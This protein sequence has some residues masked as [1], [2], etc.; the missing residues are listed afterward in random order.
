MTYVHR[1]ARDCLKS[2]SE[3]NKRT[4]DTQTAGPKYDV[5]DAVWLHSP[6][7]RKGI[8]PK[9]QSNW[10]GPYFVLD[11]L[12]DVTY[13]IQANQKS[14][15]KIVHF[16]RLK[17]YHAEEPPDW[18]RRRSEKKADM[19]YSGDFVAQRNANQDR[20]ETASESAPQ[21]VLSD[22]ADITPES[23]DS[24]DTSNEEPLQDAPRKTVPTECLHK[25]QRTKCLGC[26]MQKPSRHQ[27]RMVA[28]RQL[29]V[30]SLKPQN[31]NAQTMRCCPGAAGASEDH[32]IIFLY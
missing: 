10:Q 29:Q 9:L 32:R 27:Q 23:Q 26:H 22:Q 13:R 1:V 12:S 7:R 11:C 18:V 28:C 6:R 8:S 19:T 2:I 3:K 30:P 21:E 24:P 17:A 25:E 15:P 16:N 20:H 4:Y 5:G 14:K 31:L